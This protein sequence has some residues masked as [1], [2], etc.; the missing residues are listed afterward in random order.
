MARLRY[1][2]AVKLLGGS[3]PAHFSTMAELGRHGQEVIGELS[4]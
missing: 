4:S 3:M 2:D 1:A